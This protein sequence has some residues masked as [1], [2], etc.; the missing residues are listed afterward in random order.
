[1]KCLSHMDPKALLFC[2]PYAINAYQLANTRDPSI[3]CLSHIAII[4]HRVNI[5]K[6]P[7]VPR[8][9]RTSVDLEPVRELPAGGDLLAIYSTIHPSRVF[10]SSVPWLK[11]TLAFIPRTVRPVWGTHA[12]FR[13]V[14]L[15]VT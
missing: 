15:I 7:I 10:S 2:T 6:F 3:R 11:V 5:N 1:M 14:A 12:G 8:S 9:D 13:P 4:A